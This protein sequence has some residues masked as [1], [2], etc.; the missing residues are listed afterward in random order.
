[1]RRITKKRYHIIATSA[2]QWCMRAKDLLESRGADFYVDNFDEKPELLSEMKTQ[3]DYKTV[4]MIWEIS[5]TGAKKFI[6]GY[7]DLVQHFMQEQSLKGK[8]LLNG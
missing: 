7:S 8:S 4:P 3:M 6:G 5:E 2:C 1:M